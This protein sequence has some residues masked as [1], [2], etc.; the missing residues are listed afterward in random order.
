MCLKYWVFTFMSQKFLKST[1]LLEQ[2]PNPGISSKLGLSTHSK[3]QKRKVVMRSRKELYIHRAYR[4]DS[5]SS[6]FF[7]YWLELPRYIDERTRS[8]RSQAV[9][10]RLWVGW[11][12]S[13]AW[14]GGAL[15][16]ALRK[17]LLLTVN[18]SQDVHPSHLFLE[19]RVTDLEQRRPVGKME[20]ECQGFLHLHAQWRVC[21]K[22]QLLFEYIII[23][24][25]H[26]YNFGCLIWMSVFLEKAASKSLIGACCLL[27][28]RLII[29]SGEMNWQ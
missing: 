26:P 27:S 14:S 8:M 23:S 3:K 1:R 17:L 25:Y 29:E 11:Q 20:A 16:G 9:S 24:M 22:K 10:V 28:E 12:F 5:P 21:C 7:R 13:Q 6:P 18:S 15:S 2:R 4:E 19:P